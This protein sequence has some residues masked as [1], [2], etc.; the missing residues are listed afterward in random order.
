MDIQLGGGDTNAQKV[1]DGFAFELSLLVY[2]KKK[3][4][5]PESN[6]CITELMGGDALNNQLHVPRDDKMLTQQANSQ[7]SG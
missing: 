2:K 4:T 1:I 3:R 7:I 5:Q 6:S